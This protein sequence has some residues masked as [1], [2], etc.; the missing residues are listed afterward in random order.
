MCILGFNVAVKKFTYLEEM[1][2]ISYAEVGNISDVFNIN[3]P[4]R[5]L[6]R[7]VYVKMW[8]VIQQGI[9]YATVHHLITGNPGIGKTCFLC[10]I[11]QELTKSKEHVMIFYS[12]TAQNIYICVDTKG[13]NFRCS[14]EATLVNSVLTEEFK[15]MT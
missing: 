10:Y 13:E 14:D 3:W 7:D 9:G 11:I 12:N 5:L 15:K 1:H 6:V 2:H 4:K 8:R